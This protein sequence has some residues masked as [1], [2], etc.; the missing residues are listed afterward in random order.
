M[1]V[2]VSSRTASGCLSREFPGLLAAAAAR[3]AVG[4]RL[5][6][7]ARRRTRVRRLL[8]GRCARRAGL[9]DHAGDR[10][11]VPAN[12]RARSAL[13]NLSRG[14]CGEH[15]HSLHR[16]QFCRAAH[17]GW[18]Q[19]DCQLD[20]PGVERADRVALVQAAPRCAEVAGHCLR[21]R[22]GVG[23]GWAAAGGA[24]AISGRWHAGCS[25][26]CQHVRYR[27]LSD[28]ALPHR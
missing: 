25:T 6:V 18:L 5:H 13:E 10:D 19:R 28:Q 22:R 16:L 4:R 1:P 7:H 2:G 9:P 27:W 3:R 20:D 15:R 8:D 21:L 12:T 11:G 26:R 23:T 24:D 17:P 14:W